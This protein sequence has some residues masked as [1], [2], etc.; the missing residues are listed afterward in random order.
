[1]A[2]WRLMNAHYLN[3]PGTEWEYVEISRA[4][5]KQARVRFPVPQYLD[6]RDPS[7][8]N[9]PGE[10]VVAHAKEGEKA[11]K[12][13]PKDIIFVG[14]PT[15]DMEPMDEEAEKITKQYEH[16]WIAPMGEQALPGY[17]DYSQSLLAKFDEELTAAIQRV[18]AGKVVTMPNTSVKQTDFDKLQ[19]QVEELTK[20]NAALLAKL[21]EQNA[22]KKV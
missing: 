6:P 21:T 3:V 1:M 10:I 7:D 5:G 17:G 11:N 14:Q 9:Y 15:P 18:G 13:Y 2:R 8:H 12:F 4:S 19:K 22:V 20:Q 16:Q